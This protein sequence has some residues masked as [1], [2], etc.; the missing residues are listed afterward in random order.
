[1]NSN[2]VDYFLK[3]YQERSYTAAAK[4]VPMSAQGLTK[5]IHSLEGELGVPL[6]TPGDSGKVNPTPYAEEFRTFCLDWLAARG[7][8]DEAF[9]H[10]DGYALETIRLAAAIGA[11]SV[12]GI[13][14]VTSFRKRHPE[15]DV[16]CDDLPDLK[17][18]ESLCAGTDTLGLTVAP[19]DNA[20][21][22]VPLAS[23]E[24]Y[25]WVA[26]DDPLASK[27]EACVR[28]LQGRSV[29]LV[30]PLF[31]NYGLLLDALKQEG[32]E[33]AEIATS[34]EMMWLHQYAK[35]FGGIAFTAQSVLPLYE[36]DPSVVALPFRDMPYQ[37]GISWLKEH[38]LTKAEKA[39]VEACTERAAELRAGA[40]PIRPR[41][42]GFVADLVRKIA[43]KH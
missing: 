23:C 17:V 1:M 39:F 9:R 12:L 40:A 20:F 24:R 28:D 11:F 16:V 25:V 15:V 13:D 34:S 35:S 4:L 31:K 21:E 6:F 42:T 30:G 19:A 5:A 43:N 29:A 2:Q 22:T 14:L 38:R 7:R 37:I 8:L 10:I 32:I 3:A 27:R 26:A 33:P 18:E 41:G 36:D